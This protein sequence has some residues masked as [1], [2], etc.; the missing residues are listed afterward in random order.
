MRDTPPVWESRPD[1]SEAIA[2]PLT[3]P[4]LQR[5]QRLLRRART[6]SALLSGKNKA[7]PATAQIA[8]PALTLEY[9]NGTSRRN[10]GQES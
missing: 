8:R 2:R 10:T 5:L 9:I 3:G 6:R 1:P 7:G 4:E